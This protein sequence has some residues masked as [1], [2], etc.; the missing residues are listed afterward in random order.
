MHSGTFILKMKS[1]CVYCASSM[2]NNP[3]YGETAYYLGQTLA[4]YGI[5]LIYGG[6]KIGL[7]GKVAEGALSKN[8]KITGIIPEFLQ[9]REIAH[10]NL[11]ELII[12]QTM[13]ERKALMHELSDGFIALPGGFGTMEELFEIL[14]WA[15]L[16][17]HKK[18]VGVLNVNGYY[19][20]LVQLIEKMIDEHLLKNEYR[21]MLLISD[22]IEDLLSQMNL[23]EAPAFEKWH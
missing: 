7:M 16:S 18:P 12:V 2:G 15:Q 21:G 6:A 8:G 14:T 22:S 10:E 13:H 1:I 20:P 23:Y 4:E 11:H 19:D 3:V 9:T 17:L 5:E